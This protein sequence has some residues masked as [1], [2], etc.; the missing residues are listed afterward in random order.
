MGKALLV[1]ISLEEDNLWGGKWVLLRNLA[2]SCLICIPLCELYRKRFCG[3]YTETTVVLVKP[4]VKTWDLSRGL[5]GFKTRK[6]NIIFCGA[7]RWRI[8][9]DFFFLFLFFS[10]SFHFKFQNG[11]CKDFIINNKS[12]FHFHL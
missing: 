4:C 10:I 7:P 12:F 6:E 8:P 3:V 9:L 1:V 5:F 11:K 2:A